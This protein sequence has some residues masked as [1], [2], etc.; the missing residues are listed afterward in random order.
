MG[1]VSRT[2]QLTG[3]WARLQP[4]TKAAHRAVHNPA[5]PAA[6]IGGH[7]QRQTCYWQ[8]STTRREVGTWEGGVVGV[9]APQTGCSRI[10]GGAALGGRGGGGVSLWAGAADCQLQCRGSP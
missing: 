2:A 5:S 7:V 1:P 4:D 3:P 6:S 8:L 10:P 9:K